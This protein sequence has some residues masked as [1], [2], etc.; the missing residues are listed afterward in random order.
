MS[1]D[2]KGFLV[3]GAVG[4]VALS[5]AFGVAWYSA[6][7]QCAVYERQ[8]VHMTQ[9]EVFCGAKPIVRQLVQP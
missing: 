4:A 7:L 6:G 9:W 1:D 3:F 5:L 2:L 8:G